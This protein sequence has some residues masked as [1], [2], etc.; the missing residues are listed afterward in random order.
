MRFWVLV[1]CFFIGFVFVQQASAQSG[2]NIY[3]V[4]TPI[5]KC[6]NSNTICTDNS[7]CPLGACNVVASCSPPTTTRASNSCTDHDTAP[8]CLYAMQCSCGTCSCDYGNGGPSGPATC[9]FGN[10][11]NRSGCNPP[12]SG[13]G[14][15]PTPTGSG[16][17]GASCSNC[18]GAGCYNAGSCPA[19]YN[20]VG[21]GSNPACPIPG[22]VLCAQPACDSLGCGSQG[23]GGGSSPPT[24]GF[25]QA[26][27]E[28]QINGTSGAWTSGPLTVDRADK[29]Y[30]RPM[31]T[32][33]N[34]NVAVSKQSNSNVGYEYCGRPIH[35][36]TTTP[37]LY[38]N[39]MFEGNS[40]WGV[41]G[42]KIVVGGSLRNG[43]CGTADT[44]M[45]SG[46]II[47]FASCTVP[48][49][50]ALV[51]P[52]D[53]AQI[54]GTST[55][56]MWTPPA[57]WGSCHGYY[58][59]VYVQ[60]QGVAFSGTPTG[61]V[62]FGNGTVPDTSFNFSG[63]IGVTYKWKVVASNDGVDSAAS[64][65]WTF[66]FANPP[67]WQIA[68]GGA[69]AATNL[70]SGVAA[71]QNFDNGA[72]VG[73]TLVRTAG[74][75][76]WVASR[77]VC[78]GLGGD[79]A[80]INTAAENTTAGT[81]CGA[82]NNCFIGA[83]DQATEGTWVTVNGSAVPY[84]NWNAGE[85]NGGVN[86][87][88]ATI[89]NG[90]TWNDTGGATGTTQNFFAICELP[91]VAGSVVTPGMPAAGG[92]LGL[93]YG[94]ASA[95][96]WQVSPSVPGSRL[97]SENGFAEMKNRLQAY[98]TPATLSNGSITSASNLTAGAAQDGVYYVQVAG[99]ATIDAP[100]DV[101]NNKVVLLVN[102]NATINSTINLTDG[103]GYFA[104]LASGN[105]T[106][107]PSLGSVALVDPTTLAPALEG[108]YFAGG[109]FD[110]GSGSN[111]LRIDGSVVGMAGVTL[112]RTGYGNF[113][114]EYFAFRPD[115][116]ML[117]PRG[118]QSTSLTWQEVNP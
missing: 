29:L 11:A 4:G 20:Q 3:Q 117:T 77:T 112:Q 24:C 5:Y 95:Y 97:L 22:Q 116:F 72:G 19:T 71:G 81:T 93:G 99:D 110:T 96:N 92:S 51:V 108:A 90:G 73:T 113:P 54:S 10:Q 58:Y 98:V 79:L 39:G 87:N 37:P 40:W 74:Q 7:Q 44:C 23:G 52:V 45:I 62:G 91:V 80:T 114:A 106:V 1:L 94:N 85:P 16:G 82:G 18:G 13:G 25:G 38:N 83:T 2:C 48:G 28:I 17:G 70:S 89:N 84:I 21:P 78:Q 8:G 47:T 55:T 104:L 88:F 111:Q 66:T 32:W 101:G 103:Q 57:S 46:Q 76:S 65:T 31:P 9:T 109:T 69:T 33:Q 60:T 43:G 49:A 86:D 100:I 75:Q 14:P 64:P 6:S 26:H 61:T 56:L 53:G 36:Q 67:W 105:I 118:I 59:K 30:I 107:N 12:P 34:V 115:I 50:P 15:G 35:S 27:T 41:A 102:G 42:D 63:S 68:G